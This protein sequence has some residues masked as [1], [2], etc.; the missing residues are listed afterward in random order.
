MDKP[1]FHC[2]GWGFLWGMAAQGGTN[3]F[4]RSVNAKD[5][6]DAIVEHKVSHLCA[7][8]TVLSII[9]NA[10]PREIRPL[11]HTVDAKHTCYFFT[12]K[13]ELCTQVNKAPHG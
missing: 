5:I 3:I 6:F 2:N 11:P 9:A 7:V 1:M 4:H 13:Y 10:P 8:P 12:L